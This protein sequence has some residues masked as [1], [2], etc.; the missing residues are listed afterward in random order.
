MLL[1]MLEIRRN[2]HLPVARLVPFPMKMKLNVASD[3]FL[4]HETQGG[5]HTIS[6]TRIGTRVISRCGAQCDALMKI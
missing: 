4:L 1:N 6:F 2:G 5:C 3:V